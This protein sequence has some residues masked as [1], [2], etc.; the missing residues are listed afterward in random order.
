M[1]NVKKIMFDK[2]I[3]E[4]NAILITWYD[5]CKHSDIV[6]INIVHTVTFEPLLGPQRGSDGYEECIFKNWVSNDP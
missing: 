4:K 1:A 6:L 5:I 3:C 2:E